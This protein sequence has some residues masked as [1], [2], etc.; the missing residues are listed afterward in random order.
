MKHLLPGW[1]FHS[2]LPASSAFPQAP[3]AASRRHLDSIKRDAEHVTDDVVDL[4]GGYNVHRTSD[5]DEMLEAIGVKSIDRLFDEI[6]AALRL[7][8][9]LAL[10]GPLNEWQLRRHVEALAR[11]NTTVRSMI[12]L[13]GGGVYEH[14]VPAVVDSICSRG[15]FLTAYTPYQP[16]M[17]QGL[18]QVL[19]EYQ[20]MVGVLTGLPLANSSLYDGATAM[21]EAAWM[22]CSI[23]NTRRV[24]VSETI[25]PQWRDVFSTYMQGRGVEVGVVPE[26]GETGRVD[27]RALLGALQGG[28]WATF[29]MQ[30]PNSWGVIEDV[31][32]AAAACH[33]HG[34]LLNVSCYPIALGLLESPGA[35]GADIVTAEG[36]CLGMPL[37][38]GGPYLGIVAT[39]KANEKHLPG[40]LVGELRDLRGQ[41]A[42]ALVR[43]E[44]EQHVSRDRA[45]SHICSNQA[46]QAMRAAIYLASVGE[47]GL[48]EISRQNAAKAHFLHAALTTIPGVRAARSGSFF[49]EFAL[50]FP[51]SIDELASRLHQRG[52]FAGVQLPRVRAGDERSLLIAVT[53]VRSKP[54][55]GE[56]TRAFREVVSELSTGPGG[57]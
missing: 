9:P 55:L 28:P 35:N 49:N 51:C 6:P 10:P 21:A 20:R 15:E 42:F 13:L 41:L 34:A 46:L 3:G 54:E 38:A 18:L 57:G 29:V 16:E 12:S 30:T 23:R 53:E 50:T 25:W 48:R 27:A 4:L 32:A 19:Y 11:R 7:R 22:A 47:H 52:V 33:D 26:D 14:H 5:R 2:K 45:T 43:E 36:Q 17:S 1:R 31:G 24:L 44:R 40:R 8:R 37:S 39:Q 56:V